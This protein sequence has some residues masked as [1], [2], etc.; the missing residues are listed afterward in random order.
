[1]GNMPGVLHNAAVEFIHVYK[2]YRGQKQPAL[3]DLSFSIQPGQKVGI[4]GANGSGKSTILKLIMNFL[5]PDKGL[6]RVFGSTDLEAM[7]RH[8]GYV[9]EHQVGLATFTPREL[10][11]FAVNMVPEDGIDRHRRVDE[12]LEFVELQDVQDELVEGFSKGMVQRLQ[13]A[14]ALVHQPDVLLLDEPLS[15]LD[16]E[17]QVGVRKLMQQMR[18]KTLVLATHEL[19]DVEDFCE[20]VFILDAGKLVATLHLQEIQKS[21]YFLEFEQRPSFSLDVFKGLHPIWQAQRMGK[22]VLRIEADAEELQKFL[23][24]CEKQECPVQRITS[25]SLLEDLYLK[26]VRDAEK[27]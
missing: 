10:L 20:T 1:M 25:R 3:K 15:G 26:H 22:P 17:G 4:I 7:K 9:S 5:R 8:L 27:D 11:T 13:I 14:L 18:E 24:F 2:T 12:L 23:Q 16:P 21:I 19:Q 6:V